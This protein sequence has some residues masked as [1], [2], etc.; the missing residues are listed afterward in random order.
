MKNCSVM[1]DLHRTLNQ[2]TLNTVTAYV[3]PQVNDIDMSI[4][5]IVLTYDLH[6]D[7]QLSRNFYPGFFFKEL[8]RL[9]GSIVYHS[10]SLEFR[11]YYQ[12]GVQT[13]AANVFICFL[14]LAKSPV[15]Q[16]QLLQI[17]NPYRKTID[18]VLEKGKANQKTLLSELLTTL[19]PHSCEKC[20]GD[21]VGGVLRRCSISLAPPHSRPAEMVVPSSM[22]QRMPPEDGLCAYMQLCARYRREHLKIDGRCLSFSLTAFNS[23]RI[24]GW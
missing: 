23:C 11:A 20:R 13:G 22:G 8:S 17:I 12:N 7:N 5:A 4:R 10:P 21:W 6:P 1:P 19:R 9:F 15:H 24:F 14:V 16:C 3:D 2:Q 18:E